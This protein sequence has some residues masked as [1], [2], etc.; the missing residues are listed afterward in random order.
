MMPDMRSRYESGYLTLAFKEL[1]CFGHRQISTLHHRGG[2]VVSRAVWQ[3]RGSKLCAEFP[4]WALSTRKKV[5]AENAIVSRSQRSVVEK[6][7]QISKH[8][9]LE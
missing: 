3:Q 8:V 9:S 4:Y 5:N 2:S 7:K 6:D 1:R